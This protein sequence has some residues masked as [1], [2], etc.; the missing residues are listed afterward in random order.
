MTEILV[1]LVFTIWGEEFSVALSAITALCKKLPFICGDPPG[2][3]GGLFLWGEARI[4]YG[5]GLMISAC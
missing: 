5:K 4:P 3:L 1:I 2:K